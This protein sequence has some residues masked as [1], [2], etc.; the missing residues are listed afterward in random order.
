MHRS[1]PPARVP[2]PWGECH[3]RASWVPT[4]RGP[5]SR[6]LLP[7]SSGSCG[8][9]CPAV[10]PPCAPGCLRARPLPWRGRREQALTGAESREAWHLPRPIPAPGLSARGQGQE[11]GWEGATGFGRLATQGADVGRG[12]AGGGAALAGAI[13]G[14]Q[15]VRQEGGEGS[16]TLPLP[17]PWARVRPGAHLP[18]GGD[19]RDADPAGAGGRGAG[20]APRLPQP[21][22][23]CASW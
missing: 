23:A 22:P 16:R 20:P 21:C 3:C 6:R 9:A 4:P 15:G 5:G 1:G 17:S 2:G 14:P 10:G 12:P 18:R 13:P 7:P 19:P 11:E 8:A